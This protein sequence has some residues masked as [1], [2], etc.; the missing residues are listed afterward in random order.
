MATAA[1][2]GPS[3]FPLHRCKFIHLVRH[4]QGHHNVAGENNY[5][6]YM[7]EEFLDASLTPTG[8]QQAFALKKHLA[9]VPGGLGLELVVT[10]PLMRTMQTAA[11]VFGIQGTP[12][13]DLSTLL[14]VEGTGNSTVGT[15]LTT[16][17][18]PILAVEMCREHLGRHPCDKRSNLREYRQ[19][20]PAIDFSEIETEEDTW[21][22]AHVRESSEDLTERGRKFVS[23]LMARKETRI[24]VVSH[25]SFLIHFLSLFASECGPVVQ[26]EV[27]SG[28]NNC[29]MRSLVLIDRNASDSTVS[30]TQTHL[31][32][33]GGLKYSSS[34]DK[35]DEV[36]DGNGSI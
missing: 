26:K 21:W 5:G 6:A 27:R 34:S 24:A 31:N 29:E 14:M 28:Y 10:S 11:G 23:W 17:S 12:S 20:F 36:L 8:W 35:A 16:E 3:M 2:F 9:D 22:D 4:G 18:P 1:T 7:S 33:I 32:F 19:Q 30:P 13:Q 15:I 25:S